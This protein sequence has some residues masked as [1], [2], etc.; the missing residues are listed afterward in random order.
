MDEPTVVA[1]TNAIGYAMDAAKDVAN[2]AVDATKQVAVEAAPAIKQLTEQLLVWLRQAGEVAKEE[3]PKVAREIITWNIAADILWCVFAAVLLLIAY[4]VLRG[5][6]PTWMK[7]LN[8]PY[9][10]T[11]KDDIPDPQGIVNGFKFVGSA[12]ITLYGVIV[13]MTCGLDL[14][15]AFF[16]PRLYL[17]EFLTDLVKSNHHG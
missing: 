9:F 2:N 11:N 14:L 8:Q 5:S 12:A 15:K 10:P 6:F 7:W 16:A 13:F 1:T 3:L 4:R 17:I